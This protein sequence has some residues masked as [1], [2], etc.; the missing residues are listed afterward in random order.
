MPRPRSIVPTPSSRGSTGLERTRDGLRM[1]S[2]YNRPCGPA[3]PTLPVAS[4]QPTSSRTPPQPPLPRKREHACGWASMPVPVPGHIAPVA[5]FAQVLRPSPPLCREG[6]RD[7]ILVH[8]QTN[9][10]VKVIH[11]AAPVRSLASQKRSWNAWGHPRS[12]VGPQ[13]SRSRSGG[14]TGIPPDAPNSAV[15]VGT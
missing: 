5:Q 8:V 13:F 11:H 9:V 2:P 7:S 10:C 4:D 6:H 12:D 14:A 15:P 1:R 3:M